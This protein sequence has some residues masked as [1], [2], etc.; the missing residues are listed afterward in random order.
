MVVPDDRKI[1][2]LQRRRWINLFLN[3][4]YYYGSSI[5][6]GSARHHGLYE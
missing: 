6:V 5:D 4:V 1:L 2:L 3:E